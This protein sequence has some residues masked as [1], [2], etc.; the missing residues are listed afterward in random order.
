MKS[1]GYVTECVVNPV[2]NY[3]GYHYIESQDPVYNDWTLYASD[4]P[5]SYSWAVYVKKTEKNHV[6]SFD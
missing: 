1:V 2:M 6:V 5:N 3:T 4:H